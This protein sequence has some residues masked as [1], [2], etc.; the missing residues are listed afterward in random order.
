K[1]PSRHTGWAAV[2]D[3][4][5]RAGNIASNNGSARTAPAPRKI[6]RREI[7]FF[8]MNILLSL[9]GLGLVLRNSSHLEGSTFDHTQHQ[10]GETV[11]ARRGLSDDF[12]HR[13]HVVVFQ[14]A[15]ECV[16]KKPVRSR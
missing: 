12:S 9:L 1:N 16:C 6:A 14:P 13:R 11:L 3:S 10:G 8:V 7:A 2:C 5:V 4:A 15:A